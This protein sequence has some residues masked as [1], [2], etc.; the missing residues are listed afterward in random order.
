MTSYNC[1]QQI[2]TENLSVKK[3]N[4]CIKKLGISKVTLN[5]VKYLHLYSSVAIFICIFPFMT[6]RSR[7]GGEGSVG[8][9][10]NNMQTKFFNILRDTYVIKV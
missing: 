7:G 1:I 10:A 8:M 2:N 5:I 6:L 4:H 3:Y 9:Y